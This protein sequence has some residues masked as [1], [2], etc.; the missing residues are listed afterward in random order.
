MYI[1]RQCQVL[2]IPP[3]TLYPV[4]VDEMVKVEE[5]IGLSD[6]LYKASRP[7]IYLQFHHTI[8]GYPP[9]V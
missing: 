9:E 8:Y 5:M 3:G 6:D 7:S 2:N 1:G 4:D